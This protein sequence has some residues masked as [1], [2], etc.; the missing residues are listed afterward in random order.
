MNGV[1]YRQIS[2]RLRV[3]IKNVQTLKR[4][5][6]EPIIEFQFVR[7]ILSKFVEIRDFVTIR[8]YRWISNRALFMTTTR[9][10][11]SFKMYW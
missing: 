8:S 2:I 7:Q 3:H 5:E 9:R 11:C 1:P 6:V 10:S 4:S